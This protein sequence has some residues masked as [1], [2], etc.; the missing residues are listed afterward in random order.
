MKT[1]LEVLVDNDVL[2]KPEISNFNLTLHRDCYILAQ[3]NIHRA[4]IEFAQMHV[5]EA[6]E[7]ACEKAKMD[8]FPYD[9]EAWEYV[10]D[11]LIVSD[12]TSDMEDGEISIDLDSILN[13]YP[14]ENIK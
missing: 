5:K 13:A 10:D 9:Q 3:N 8:V 2:G 12:L 7:Q 11:V 14:K 4:M 1:A 6:L